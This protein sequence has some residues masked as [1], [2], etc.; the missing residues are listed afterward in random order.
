MKEFNIEFMDERNIVAKNR[1]QMLELYEMA[2]S[3]KDCI[4]TCLY[5]ENIVSRVLIGEA[6]ALELSNAMV[7]LSTKENIKELEEKVKSRISNLIQNVR[8]AVSKIESEEEQEKEEQEKEEQE[9][10][11]PKPEEKPNKRK[12]KGSAKKTPK[13][14][15]VKRGRGRPKK[16]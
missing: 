13:T 2:V 15:K 7:V 16:N 12:S 9:K 5:N 1:T 6:F 11:E 10:E 14:E 8:C 3:E 4:V